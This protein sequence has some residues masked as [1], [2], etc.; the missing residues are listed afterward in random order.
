MTRARQGMFIFIPNGD[1]DD[2]TRSPAFYDPIWEFFK[3]C[4]IDEISG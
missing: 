4:G 2:P 1:P 3:A